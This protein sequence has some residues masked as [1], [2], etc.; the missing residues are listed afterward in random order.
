ME[1]KRVRLL[2]LSFSVPL[3]DQTTENH[4][5]SYHNLPLL[6]DHLNLLRSEVD[7]EED[8]DDYADNDY[9]E[10]DDDDDYYDYEEEEGAPSER[11]PGLRNV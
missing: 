8:D 10:G 1:G 6:S 2:Q 3:D 4:A 5:S 7:R 9:K 11:S